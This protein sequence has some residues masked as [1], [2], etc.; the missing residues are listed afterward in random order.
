MLSFSILSLIILSVVLLCGIMLI[1]SVLNA[2]MLNGMK[3]LLV[4]HPPRRGILIE[5]EGSGL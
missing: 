4:Y 5:G 3:G 2:I 1:V